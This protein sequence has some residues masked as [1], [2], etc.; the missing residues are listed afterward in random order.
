MDDP[1]YPLPLI[2]ECFREGRYVITA[3]AMRGAEGLELDDQDIVECIERL[4]KEHFYKTMP[5]AKVP[6]LMQ[7][8]YKIRYSGVPIY[9]KVQMSQTG[10]A[11]A[12]SFK[13]D[14]SA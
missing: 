8:V 4:E 6:G 13:L 9:L 14:E 11:V 10:K 1:S 7:D 2:K 3:S 12:I 5:A